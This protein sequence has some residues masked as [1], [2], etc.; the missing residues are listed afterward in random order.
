VN[1]IYYKN[2]LIEHII[3]ILPFAQKQYVDT[4]SL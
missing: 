2:S 4:L 1:F 3:T